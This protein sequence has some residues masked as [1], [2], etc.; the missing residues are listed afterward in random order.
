M[1][2][3]P[4]KSASRPARSSVDEWSSLTPQRRPTSTHYEQ[5][6]QRRADHITNDTRSTAARVTETVSMQITLPATLSRSNI[7]S[8]GAG[9]SHSNCYWADSPCHVTQCRSSSI[10][11]HSG[12]RFCCSPLPDSLTVDVRHSVTGILHYRPLAPNFL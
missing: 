5:A 8:V 7:A 4:F 3:T 9:M 1:C 12:E 6:L 11:V 10:A 2:R